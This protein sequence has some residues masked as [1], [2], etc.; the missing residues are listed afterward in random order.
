MYT[1]KSRL[2]LLMVF[3]LAISSLS[4][5]RDNEDGRDIKHVLLISVDGMHALDLTELHRRHIPAQQWRNSAAM[6]LRI[7]THLRHISLIHSPA[8]LR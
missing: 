5:A 4:F 7:P 6:A 8:W 3:A 2:F 1:S